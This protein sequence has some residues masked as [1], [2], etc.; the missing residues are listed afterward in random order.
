[1][2]EIEEHYDPVTVSTEM[3]QKITKLPALIYYL[4]SL[5][6]ACIRQWLLLQ[7]QYDHSKFFERFQANYQRVKG[8]ADEH[9]IE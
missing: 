6:V 2:S 3:H 5:M 8:N 4:A 1:M 9:A 7:V